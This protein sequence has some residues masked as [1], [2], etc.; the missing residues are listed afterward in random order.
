METTL[1][2]AQ[3]LAQERLDT[4]DSMR[5]PDN[6]VG[7]PE[8]EQDLVHIRQILMATNLRYDI[9]GDSALW[10]LDEMDFEDERILENS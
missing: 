4:I 3:R 6:T 5:L 9:S 7:E 8:H 1:E 2:R 10:I